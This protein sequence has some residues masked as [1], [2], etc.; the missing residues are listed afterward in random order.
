[1]DVKI[2]DATTVDIVGIK[3]LLEGSPSLNTDS[4]LRD[5]VGHIGKSECIA[6][7]MTNEG[8]LV[9][10]WLSKEFETH[11]SLSFFFIAEEMRRK[12]CVL[13]FFQECLGKV[14]A[15]KPMLI[16]AK[17]ITGFEKYVVAVEGNPDVYAF[18][19]FR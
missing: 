8:K 13:Q 4:L 1:M 12:I 6:K 17:D 9:G 18:K 5:V 10:V 2:R 15:S 14:S 3:R 7:V 19:G 16:G 11:T